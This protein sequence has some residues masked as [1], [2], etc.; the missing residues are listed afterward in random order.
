V[1]RIARGIFVVLLVGLLAA[2]AV[3]PAQSQARKRLVWA[4]SFPTGCIDP[5][6][7][8][9]LPDW[10]LTMNVYSGLVRQKPGSLAE[11]EPDL[12]ERWTVNRD[13]TQFTFH[14]RS[15][16]RWHENH[17]EFTAEDVKYSWERQLNPE[18]RANSAADLRRVKSIEVVDPRTVRV[19]LDQPFPAFLVTIANSAFTAIVNRRA[20]QERGT[21][22]CVRPIGTG[23]Y[24][25]ARAE[26][27]GGAL[28]IA[29]D[30]YF[31]G[32][33][34]IDEVEMRII[35]EES[36][37]VLAFRAGELDMMVVRE[38]PNIALLRRTPNIIVNADD[39]FAA[40]VYQLTINNTRR[41]FT[42]VRVRRALLHA[43]DRR[44]I[45]LRVGAGILGQISHSHIPPAIYGFTNDV[46]KYAYNPSRAK[47]LLREAGYPDGFRAI[48]IAPNTAYHPAILTIVQAMWKQ[49]GVDL[50]IQLL[51]GA[52][53]RPRQR[54]GDFDLT[55][56]DPTESEVGQHLARLDSREIPILNQSQYRGTGIDG[57]IDAQARETNPQRRLAIL[58]RIQ[59]QLATDLPTLPLFPTVQATASRSHVK[60]M[61]PNLGWWQ[62]Q[63][64]R[65]D[66]ER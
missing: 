41:P 5:A 38:F 58:K 10:Q 7:S 33:P 28:L 22:H 1:N 8:N 12:A 54:A 4:V 56:G 15:G 66:I 52:A 20:I 6:Y 44:T 50:Q 23:P 14:L 30:Q 25:V 9:R 18:T 49:V 36:V 40:S 19:T 31:G 61:V 26:A 46:P 60:G 63:F 13:F 59:Q 17:G 27:R 32:R 55:S 29:N 3:Q 16:V 57:L 45:M 37:S 43:L 62:Q 51:D 48:V 47:Q 11:V 2:T 21:S 24:Q 65:M 53:L 34:K 42:D 35:L 39:K 64:Y